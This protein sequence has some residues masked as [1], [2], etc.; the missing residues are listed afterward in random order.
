[1]THSYGYKSKTRHLF[2]KKFR[3]HGVPSVSTILT[4]YKVGQY[5]DVVADAAVRAGMPHKYYHGRTGIVWNVTPRGVGVII[6]KPHRNRTLRK[7]ICVRAEHVRPSACRKQFV[8]K[9]KAF[10]AAQAAKKAGK[11]LPKAVSKRV[12]QTVRPAKVENLA[13]TWSDYDNY[14]D[15]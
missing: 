3:R 6:N 2:A 11:T 13:R 12:A 4:T 5:V 10:V 7:R 15:Y 1:M 9:Q 14:F 8:E